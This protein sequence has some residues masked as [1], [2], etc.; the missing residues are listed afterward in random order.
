MDVSCGALPFEEEVI[1]RA[2]RVDVGGLVVPLAT[3]ED[4][5]VMKAIAHRGRDM[6]DIE[7]ILDAQPK[8]D[9]NRVRR[10]V[11]EFA[12]VLEMPEIADDLEKLLGNRPKPK[13]KKGK[14]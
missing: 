12:A 9:V 11:G 7:A 13:K 8:L 2:T 3:P 5:I 4:L 1:A 6:A 14:S 10:W